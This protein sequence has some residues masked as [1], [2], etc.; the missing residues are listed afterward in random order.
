M[1]SL[2]FLLIF[3]AATGARSADDWTRGWDKTDSAMAAAAF[4]LKVIDWKQTHYI[5]RN[6]AQH[7]EWNPILGNHPSVGRVN[8]YFL[9]SIITTGTVTYFLPDF[10]RKMF[11]G[12]SITVSAWLTHHNR[13]VGIKAEW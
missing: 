4:T 11:L 10:Y 12:G 5:A 7:H 3:L 9:G 6:P 8:N 1:R 13:S 2:F